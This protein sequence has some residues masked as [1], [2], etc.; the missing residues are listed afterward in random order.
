MAIRRHLG[1][2]VLKTNKLSRGVVKIVREI[3]DADGK[4][5]YVDVKNHR[6]WKD[7][8][9]QGVCDTIDSI[10]FFSPPERRSERYVTLVGRGKRLT[11]SPIRN[12]QIRVQRSLKRAAEEILQVQ[13]FNRIEKGDK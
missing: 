11:R 9:R 13:K 8:I 12:A 7:M 3:M 5:H 2:N 6:S 4:V 1:P 10:F